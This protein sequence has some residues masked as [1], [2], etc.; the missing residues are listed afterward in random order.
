VRSETA[1]LVDLMIPF[2]AAV[3]G[4]DVATTV[5]VLADCDPASAETLDT[6]FTTLQDAR[7]EGGVPVVGR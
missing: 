1:T 6:R 5:A 3:K 2:A 7:D 4:G